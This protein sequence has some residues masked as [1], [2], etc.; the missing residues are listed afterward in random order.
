MRFLIAFVSLAF[1]L[2]ARAETP[3]DVFT[4]RI[5]P[6]FQSP[7]PS[8]C[9]Q[10]HLSGVDLKDYIRPTHRETFLSLRDQGLVDLEQPDKSKI[11]RLIAMG[12]D[13]KSATEN[14]TKRR[15]DETE[16]FAAWIRASA[17][18]KELRDAPKLKVAE[19]A[20]PAKPDAVIRH[21][22]KERLLATF[23]ETVWAMRFRCFNCHSPDGPSN[24]KHVAEHGD[25]VTW[26]ASDAAG[27]L[28]NL[29]SSSLMSL[30][31][32]ERSPL[33]R[34]A[35]GEGKHG[36]GVKFTVGDEGY[37]AYRR[38]LDDYAK[39]VTKGYAT[40]ADLPKPE[41]HARFGTDSYLK[42]ENVPEAWSGKF[43]AVRLFS[44]DASGRWSA[45][46]M[47]GAERVVSAERRAWQQNLT[48]RAAAGSTE[49]KDWKATPPKIP[50]GKYLVKI[51]VDAADRLAKDWRAE[52]TETDCV[53]RIVV[54]SDW[55][56]GHRTVTTIDAATVKKE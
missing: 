55:P 15:R 13:D 52:L 16:A 23:E 7:N 10:C 40:A 41:T 24:K 4:K 35:L 2:S 14:Q 39:V 37:K 19:L 36:G 33:L 31:N 44:R 20:K 1:A 32:P 45:S 9:T 43:V 49:S 22:R 38:F 48:L 30:S 27:T 11:L 29:M 3:E 51:Y 17:A 26:M 46:P 47:A 50:P 28:T 54:E 5:V 6:I 18:D 12:K 21:A 53:G 42:F 8:S 34:K 56:K 25:R